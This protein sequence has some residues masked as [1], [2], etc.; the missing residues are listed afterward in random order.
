MRRSWRRV[1][2]TI[3]KL[4]I[5]RPA[6]DRYLCVS[7]SILAKMFDLSVLLTALEFH[8][9]L[10]R[11]AATFDT[12]NID[13]SSEVARS[14]WVGA[15]RVKGV[16][17]IS[18]RLDCRHV[19]QLCENIIIGSVFVLYTLVIIKSAWIDGNRTH[20]VRSNTANSVNEYER[21]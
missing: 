19:A 8:H 4:I 20:A 18:R 11:Y 7:H 21:F 13:E 12:T 10:F 5:L 15:V 2:I 3:F 14:T 17:E 9:M 6:Y 16:S 1:K